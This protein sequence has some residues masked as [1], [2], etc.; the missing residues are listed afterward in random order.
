MNKQRKRTDLKR[1]VVIGGG[2]AG[3][4]AALAAVGPGVGV[5]LLERNA[6]V[7]RKLYITGK[8]RCNLTNDC[9]AEEVL[10]NVP[11]NSRF[12]T[13]A[14]TRFPPSAVKA[15][16]TDLGVPLK[17]ERGNRV[18]PASDKAADVIDALLRALR[19][20]RVDL[21]QDRA[22]QLCAEAGRITGVR[23]E[24]SVYPCDAAI[25]C[26]GGV[27]YPL[28]GSTGDGYRMA[29]DMGHTIQPPRGSLV[30]L[31][32]AECAPMQGL[33]LRNVALKITD[34][35]GKS[36][37][38]EQGELL[39]T[40]FGLSGPLVLS[41]SAHL[42]DFDGERYTAWID[43][44]PALDEG[45]LDRRL[46]RELGEGSNKDLRH[47]LETLEPRSLIPLLLARAGLSGQEKGHEITRTQ[48]KALAGVLKGLEI[49]ITGPRPVEEAIVT[50]GGVTVTEI[51]PKDMASKRVQGLYLA[52]EVLDVDAYTGGFNLQIAWATGRAAGLAARAALTA[53]DEASIFR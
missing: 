53:G 43:L 17:T 45:A 44:K 48:R 15:Y 4:M 42:R 12:L 2:A 26:T 50:A 25:L 36:L 24:H 18:F 13:S 49:P 27:S 22:V 19:K 21:V 30:P 34:R 32:G 39:F 35:K 38:R 51:S 23:G 8:G 6:K 5:T 37:Y 10:Q 1:I 52:G 40:H 46:V 14:M 47:I 33:S 9:S 20:S 41:A 7:G 3:M 11:H 28:T 31:E 29:R 16:F